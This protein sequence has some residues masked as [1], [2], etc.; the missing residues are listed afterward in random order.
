VITITVNGTH[1]YTLTDVQVDILANEINRD[2]LEQQLAAFVVREIVRRYEIA[3]E[4]LKKE[5]D[6][7]LPALG[8]TSAPINCE[9]YAC[10]VFAQ[11]TYSDKKARD[12]ENE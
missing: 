8:V 12:S 7:K 11:P 3:F 1:A 4:N 9:D 2:E 6:K 5:W 10:L